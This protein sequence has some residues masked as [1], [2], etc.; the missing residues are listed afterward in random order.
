MILVSIIPEFPC[1]ILHRF[2]LKKLP[3]Q[4]IRLNF[5]EHFLFLEDTIFIVLT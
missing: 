1:N 5:I 3:N 2:N 4:F